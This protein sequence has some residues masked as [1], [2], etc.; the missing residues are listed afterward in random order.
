MFVPCA[1][2][3]K[4]KK[5]CLNQA[6]F[7]KDNQCYCGIHAKQLF[8]NLTLPACTTECVVC[9]NDVPYKK[10]T[11]T[12][13]KHVFCNKCIQKWLRRNHTCPL[14]RT[15]LRDPD[16]EP[17]PLELE[18]FDELVHQFITELVN[19]NQISLLQDNNL[20]ITI[21]LDEQSSRMLEHWNNH[22]R[23]VDQL[24]HLL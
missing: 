1:A 17:E 13:C 4:Q 7:K 2:Q 21:E 14:C 16:P 10:A 22:V 18:D 24:I 23:T 8:P 19:N 6:R 12:V 15:P 20:Y 11:E 3:T 5:P 9:Y